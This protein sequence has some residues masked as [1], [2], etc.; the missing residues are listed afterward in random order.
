MAPAV[1]Y[2][3]NNG[4]NVGTLF[5]GKKLFI[6]QRVPSRPRWVDLVKANG[7][8]IVPLEINADYVV[9]DHVRK[10][11]PPGSISWTFIQDSLKNGELEDPD[12]HPAGPPVGTVRQA[13]SSQPVKSTRKPFTADDDRILRQWVQRAEQQGLSTKGNEIYQQLELK[14]PNHT[15]Q[16]WRDHWVKKLAHMPQRSEPENDLLDDGPRRPNPTRTRAAPTVRRSPRN[17]PADKIPPNRGLFAKEEVEELFKAYYEIL[18]VDETKVDQ[19]WEE[20][21]KEVK[22]PSHTAEEWRTYFREEVKPRMES[23]K[24]YQPINVVESLSEEAELVDGEPLNTHQSNSPRPSTANRQNG[25][26]PHSEMAAD[27][28]LY[29]EDVF[30]IELSEFAQE[31][32]FEVNFNPN[33]CGR[34]IPLFRIWQVVRSREFGGFNNVEKKNLWASVCKK[35]KFHQWRDRDAP[36]LLKDC[37]FQNLVDFEDAKMQYLELSHAEMQD[38][39]ADLE[40]SA[41][42]TKKRRLDT[43]NE[44][45]KRQRINKGKGKEREIPSTPEQGDTNPDN[46]IQLEEDDEGDSFVDSKRR[47]MVNNRPISKLARPRDPETQDFSFPGSDPFI[48]EDSFMVPSEDDS[49][50]QAEELEDYIHRFIALGYKQEVVI[51]ALEATTME[52]GDAGIVMEALINGEGIPQNMQ[53][54]WTEED[55]EALDAPEDSDDFQRILEKHGMDIVATRQRY[56]KEKIEA[57]RQLGFG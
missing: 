48:I 16:S 12:A 41:S 21:A 57:Q 31:M 29:D 28:S 56:M 5:E 19:A 23:S 32:D 54:V 44:P 45:N 47:Q 3:S 6:A 10:N 37:C 42:S 55:D 13:G 43:N 30:K 15:W 20:W 26:Q 8:A 38:E 40:I 52:T 53:G 7:G 1:V 51:M 36:T 46:V 11:N 27:T 18:A 4:N 49:Q 39:D 33:I 34:G 14:H 9:C 35:L 24:E 2:N 25:F 50:Q 17:K 22:Y